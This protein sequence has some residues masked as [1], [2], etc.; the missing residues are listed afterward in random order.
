MHQLRV[1]MSK[2]VFISVH[3][4]PAYLSAVKSQITRKQR[5]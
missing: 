4:G 5:C 3:S 1:Y 2:I